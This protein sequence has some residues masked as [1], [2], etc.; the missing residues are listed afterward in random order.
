MNG[1]GWFYKDTMADYFIMN[2]LT[3]ALDMPMARPRF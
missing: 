2:L 3:E 1:S